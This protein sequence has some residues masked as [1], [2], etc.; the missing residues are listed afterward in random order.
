MQAAYRIEQS[1]S[2]TRGNAAMMIAYHTELT[3]HSAQGRLERMEQ[4]ALSGDGYYSQLPAS[5]PFQSAAVP[6][7]EAFRFRQDG[8]HWEVL[9]QKDRRALFLSTM[10]V[11]T[12]PSGSRRS[13]KCSHKQANHKEVRPI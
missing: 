1:G 13:P 5:L 12:C 11:G 2:G 10:A 4:A 6:G 9:A 3:V 8:I 7:A